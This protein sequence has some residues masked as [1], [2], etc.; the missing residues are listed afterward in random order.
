MTIDNNEVTDLLLTAL[1]MT[2]VFSFFNSM[3]MC[4]EQMRKTYLSYYMNWWKDL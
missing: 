2:C 1:V 3:I 4:Y